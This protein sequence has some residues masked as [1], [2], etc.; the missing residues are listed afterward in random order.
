MSV[1]RN[2]VTDDLIKMMMDAGTIM[3][4]PV[5]NSVAPMMY[6]IVRTIVS[7]KH[8]VYASRGTAEAVILPSTRVAFSLSV[9]S[10]S[11]KNPTSLVVV[12][13]LCRLFATSEHFQTEHAPQI[14]VSS[15]VLKP[16]LSSL[17]SRTHEGLYSSLLALRHPV[18]LSRFVASFVWCGRSRST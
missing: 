1:W 5:L 3:A 18:Y 4:T 17:H 10:I 7:Q 14:T 13:A 12:A 16:S 11:L 2:T 9:F 6:G 15:H 8:V